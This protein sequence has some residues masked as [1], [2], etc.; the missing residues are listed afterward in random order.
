MPTPESSSSA[1]NLGQARY[2]MLQTMARMQDEHNTLVHAQWRT[3]GYAYYRAIWVE[4]AEMLDH[5]GWKWWKKQDGDLDQVKLELVDIWHFALSELLRQ[6]RLEDSVADALFAVDTARASENKDEQEE[7]FRLAIE[8]LA[9][10]CLR[11]RSFELQPFVDAMAALPMTLDELFSL[12]I[13]KNV[14]NG[15]RQ[16]NGYK[17]GEYRKLWQGREDNEH[18]IEVLNALTATPNELPDAL[19]AAL[20]QR[21]DAD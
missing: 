11:T 17:S 5:F 6:D 18:L 21:Y 20:Q 19:Y 3:Q 8:A 15:F 1:S 12:Y 7:R 2:A 4:C 14:L 9:Q 16:N 10:G 13:G